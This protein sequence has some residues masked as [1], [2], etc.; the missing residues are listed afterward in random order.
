MN[1][2]QEVGRVL[3]LRREGKP[4]EAREFFEK[5]RSTARSNTGPWGRFVRHEGQ[6]VVRIDEGSPRSQPVRTSCQGRAL[7]DMPSSGLPPDEAGANSLLED[8]AGFF[9]ALE[10]RLVL[11]EFQHHRKKW[12]KALGE[13]CVKRAARVDHGTGQPSRPFH[14][15]QLF[16]IL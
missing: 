4:E 11:V 9:D 15:L 5:I 6:P 3:A 13:A 2:S 1:L 8:R 10:K 14:C 16:V 7:P 12:L